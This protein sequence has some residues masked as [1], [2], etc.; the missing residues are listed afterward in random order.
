LRPPSAGITRARPAPGAHRRRVSCRGSVCIARQKIHVGVG[1]AG[2]TVTVEEADTT[3]RVYL[4]DQLLTEAV[5][6]TTTKPIARF[7]ER[8]PEPPRR[9]S[10]TLTATEMV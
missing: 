2:H 8:K 5:R 3:F 1:H 7:K 4:G 9:T 10:T 6:T